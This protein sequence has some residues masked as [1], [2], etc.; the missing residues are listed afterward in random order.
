LKSPLEKLKHAIRCKSPPEAAKFFFRQLDLGDS[1]MIAHTLVLGYEFRETCV[2]LGEVVAESMG[3]GPVRFGSGTVI[4]FNCRHAG[5][6]LESEAFLSLPMECF[7]M[8]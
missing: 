5:T 6:L 3:R 8:V 4:L 2:L 7:Q 1:F